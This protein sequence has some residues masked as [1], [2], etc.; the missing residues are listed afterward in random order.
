MQIGIRFYQFAKKPADAHCRVK[1]QPSF[2]LKNNPL[3]LCYFQSS[4]LHSS[5]KEPML[6]WP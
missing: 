3:E 1:R 4:R 2:A 5:F 6:P